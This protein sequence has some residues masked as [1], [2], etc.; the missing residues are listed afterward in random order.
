[1]ESNGLL[2]SI[3]LEEINGGGHAADEGLMVSNG[4]LGMNATDMDVLIDVEKSV[5]SLDCGRGQPGPPLLS[6]STSTY[7]GRSHGADTSDSNNHSNGLLGSGSGAESSWMARSPGVSMLNATSKYLAAQTAQRV[8]FEAI[9]G[10]GRSVFIRRRE[11]RVLGQFE[12]AQPSASASTSTATSTLTSASGAGTGTNSFQLLETPIWKLRQERKEDQD[13]RTAEKLQE[14][15]DREAKLLRRNALINGSSTSSKGKE[16]ENVRQVMWVDKYRPTKFTDLLGDERCHREV[17]GWLKEWDRCVFK[18]IAP[19]KKRPRDGELGGVG[20]SDPIGRPRDRILLMSGPPGLGKTTL[21][22]IV[23][24]QA[25][26]EVFEVNASDDRTASTVSNRIQNAIDAGSGLRSKGRP[27]CVIIDEI[28]GAAGGGD[29]GFIK[30]LCKL[31]Q[32]VPARVKT[33]TPAKLLRRPI[34]CICNDLYAP[35]LRPLRQSA[36]IIRFRKSQPALMVSRLKDICQKETLQADTRSLTT[37]VEITNADVRSCLNTLQF[38]QAKAGEVSEK[39]IRQSAVG[40][41]DAG[42]SLAGVWHNLFVPPTT[43]RKKVVLGAADGKY[44]N[45]LAFEIQASGDMDK[46]VQG[47]SADLLVSALS[48]GFLPLGGLRFSPALFFSFFYL[49]TWVFATGCFE[50]YP[51]LKPIDTSLNNI[52]K[53]HNWVHFFDVLSGRVGRSQEFELMAYMPYGVVPWHPHMGSPANMD[54]PTEFPKADYEVRLHLTTADNA[55]HL[56]DE[57]L[58]NSAS[59]K[60]KST[61]R[62]PLL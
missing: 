8:S 20:Y 11:R 37:L 25:G 60:H 29:S 5:E 48:P 41:K 28:D 44:V 57:P 6:T 17:L 40:L 45:R 50:H 9:L 30:S 21:A 59:F 35:A 1:M 56:T 49:F 43:K 24:K 16:R 39:S 61:R 36:R 33:N 14:Q 27:T 15:Y 58:C 12:M 42:S 26:Y 19:I 18:T 55:F 10:N 34:I 3:I 47:E 31:I 32:D 4:L 54:K 23:A 7:A 38:I 62:L 22:H 52:N 13:R 46:V 51:N 53:I 2:D